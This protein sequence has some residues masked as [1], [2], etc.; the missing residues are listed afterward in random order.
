MLRTIL[1]NFKQKQ[2]LDEL[3]PSM[4]QMEKQLKQLRNWRKE[5]HAS[6]PAKAEPAAQQ[7]VRQS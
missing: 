6:I 3:L 1:G 7:Q 4:L 2:S 5:W